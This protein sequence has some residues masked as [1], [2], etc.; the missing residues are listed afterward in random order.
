MPLSRPSHSIPALAAACLLCNL[1]VATSATDAHAQ[2]A[3]QPQPGAPQAPTVV[4]QQYQA[5]QQQYQQPQYQQPQYAQP[6]QYQAP[7][8]Q[9]QPQY[10]LQQPGQPQFGGPRIITDWDDSRPVPAGY[11]PETRVRKGL[12]IGGAVMFGAMYLLTALTAAA[13]SDASSG[14]SNVGALY[15]PG[16]G[17]F[18]FMSQSSSATGTFAL[19]VDGVVQIG[20]LAMFIAGLAAPRNVLVRNDLGLNLHFTP[21][22]GRDRS[23]MALAGTF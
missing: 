9:V 3:Q 20:G 8:Y 23:G 2:E 15:S 11:H 17:P 6:Q 16:A 14:S 13:V 4:I 21:V 19:A 5:P 1:A 22:I 18:I 7:V 10:V 12:V